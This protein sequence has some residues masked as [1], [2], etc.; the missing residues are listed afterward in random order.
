M[1]K[2][3]KAN[4]L[5]LLIIFFL[6]AGVF[7]FWHFNFNE[8][9]KMPVAS[10]AACSATGGTVTQVGGYCVHTFTSSGTFAPGSNVNNLEVL[11]VAG[12]GG[13]GSDLGGGGGGGGVIYKSNFPAVNKIASCK[14]ILD[15]GASTG[16]GLYTID[17]DG[18]EGNAPFQVYC[19]MTTD[20]GGWTRLA[21]FGTAYNI[22]G[23]TYTSGLAT[24]T[25]SEY[26]HQCSL[27][28][29]IGLTDATL[30]INMGQVKDYYKPT[31]SYTICQ[32]IAESPGTH[33]QWASTYNGTFQTPSYYSAHLG[34]SAVDWPASID[35]RR[36]LSFWGGGGSANS[37][38]CHNTS[39]V[40]GG[41]ID[42]AAW[43]RAFDMYFR[44]PTRTSF[45]VTVG[46]GGLG[47]Q[48]VRK[49]TSLGTNGGNS[50][51]GPLIAIGGGGGGS[52]WA[53]DSAYDV[54][55]SGGSG[56]GNGAKDS[57]V[58]T[59]VSTGTAGQGNSGGTSGY[60]PGYPG[61]GGGGAGGV[62][63]NSGAQTGGGAGGIGVQYSISGTPTYYGGGGG[64][65][66]Y[67]SSSA[68]TSGGAGGL[69]GGGN[70]GYNVNSG[71]TSVGGNGTANTGG[72]GGG[73]SWTGSVPSI[74]GTGGSGI[75]IVRY[76]MPITLSYRKP[77]TINNTSYS[78]A[79]TGYQIP[80]TV[81]TASL[82]T[83]GKLQSDCDDL[84]FTDSS[85][86]YNTADWTNN[87]PYWIESG[88]NTSATKIWVKVDSIAASTSKVI[89]MYYGNASA[90]SI[91]NA[92]ATF[93][94]YH[95]SATAEFHDSNV[96]N[97][98][99]IASRHN[100]TVSSAA[101]Q[102]IVFG[103]TD[104][105]ASS[106]CSNLISMQS[107]YSN[108]SKY[109]YAKAN[110]TQTSYY[111]SGI[112]SVDVPHIWEIKYFNGSVHYFVDEVEYGT[113]I[114]A[115]LP[116]ASLGLVYWPATGTG[117]V[118]NWSLIRK[119]V[120]PEPTISLGTEDSPSPVLTQVTPI[121][122]STT[123]TTPN[124]TFNSTKAGT[125]T[126]GGD[127][128]SATT[129]AVAGDNTITFNPLAA[130]THSNCTI[131]VSGSNVLTV[132]SFTVISYTS[133]EFTST[134]LT[135][136]VIS[137][138][139][140]GAT[141]LNLYH[142]NG[143]HAELSTQNYYP[144]KVCCRGT[145]VS[146][147]CSGN[148]NTVLKLSEATNAHVEE[149]IF[150]N[151]ANNACLSSSSMGV[152]CGYST[153]CSALGSNYVCLASISGD[154]DAH[155]GECSVYSTKVC[156]SLYP[157][158]DTCRAKVA[159]S[160]SVSLKDNDIQMCSGTNINNTSDPCYPVC[161]KGTG[162]PDLTSSDWKCSVCHDSSN[163]PV[164]CSTLADT[165][166]SWTMP[167]GYVLDTDYTL[168]SGTLASANPILRFAAQDSNRQV[169]LNINSL[170]T[171]CS[172]QNLKLLTPKWKEVSPFK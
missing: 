110:G 158:V 23:S 11:V 35:G 145:G 19:D 156:C 66:N 99:G 26:A 129:A 95:A 68:N 21:K 130:G 166:F 123:D 77:V 72:G 75:V 93:I 154:T 157:L 24:A 79:L 86:S 97:G 74:G 57:A 105:L 111:I 171:T 70:G 133:E 114:T 67:S 38:C 12:G 34:G 17:P 52:Y 136:S 27:F 169:T 143:N 124:Y 46:A 8:N 59:A 71:G 2:T 64:G 151:Y 43:N 15:A 84:R 91:N 85:A 80:V 44:E 55:K 10:A 140:S 81:D 137:G 162:T 98:P 104:C 138:S 5:L 48:Q 112:P 33:F 141:I 78:S 13:G 65:S 149:K 90:L 39:N 153:S 170:G 144:Y 122:A 37:G 131:A 109:A 42:T 58:G 60:N 117:S 29:N 3:Q 165:T 167:A 160:Q 47:G 88:C 115:N 96:A 89:Y 49:S 103:L 159:S 1:L 45:A 155:I 20:G 132:P 22:T 4:S 146:N 116:T 7:C 113:G 94:Q 128:S 148:Y 101:S 9:D 32:M 142:Y 168:V 56:G 69:G 125:I 102:N 119:Y 41:S 87:Y 14:A 107:Y 73:G 51:F 62:G 63:G 127:C 61:G 126:Y 121:A 40:Y 6:V 100:I 16:D 92:S 120:S 161:W 134:N 82:I 53:S 139:C 163:N 135:C 54:G 108:T 30:R 172:N 164:S 50:V 106:I 28:N 36:Y 31:S 150:S 147:S 118:H 25:A 18:S 76:P 152:A 83:A